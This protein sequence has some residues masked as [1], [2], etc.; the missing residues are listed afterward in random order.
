MISVGYVVLQRLFQLLCLRFRSTAS[1]E[2]EIVVLRHQLAVVA[3]A[4]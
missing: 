1:Q 4:D 2:L 3:P